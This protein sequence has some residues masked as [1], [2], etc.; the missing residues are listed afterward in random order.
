[1]ETLDVN[2]DVKGDIGLEEVRKG[3][4]IAAIDL[5]KNLDAKWVLPR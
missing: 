2:M 5:N 4:V 3:S 1:M